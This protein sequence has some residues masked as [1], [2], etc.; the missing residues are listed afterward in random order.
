MSRNFQINLR[1]L[2]DLL[3]NHLY[4]SPEVF[5]REL[6]QNGVD[7]IQ[8][9]KLSEA[10]DPAYT[11][12][13]TV[14]LVGGERPTLIFA[15][16]GVGLSE[17]GVHRF[18]ATIGSSSKREDIEERR[19]DFIGQ[20]GIGILACFMVADEIVVLSRTADATPV[21]WRGQSDGTYTVRELETELS[22]GTQVFLRSMP[23]REEFFAPDRVRRLLA[24]FGALFPYPVYLEI[25][26]AR[27]VHIN[28]E[29]APWRRRYESE[30]E[31]RKAFVEYGQRVFDMRLFDAI[32]I[33][34]AIG[35][36]EGIACILPWAPGPSAR[37]S[38][39]VY[40]KNM[41]LTD[42]G[43][44]LLPEWA[45]FVKCVV[46]AGELQPTA[47][48]ESFYENA[49]LEQAR[50][51][52]GVCI[53]DYLVRLSRDD[54]ETLR[55]LISLHFLSFKALAAVDEEF[56]RMFIKWLPFETSL[57]TMSMGEYLER[58][59]EYVRYTTTVEEFRQISQVALAGSLP[60]INAGYVYDLDLIERLPEVYGE[61]EV[62]RIDADDLVQEF[63]DLS[64]PERDQT[65]RLM[66]VADR[67]LGNFQ[68]RPD[69]KK[70]LPADLPA[71]YSIGQEALHRRSLEQT[72]EI[73]EGLWSGVLDS[74]ARSD[75]DGSARLCFNFNN[76]LVKA[77]CAAEAE[78]LLELY[79]KMIYVQSL[80]LGH[81]PLQ[82]RELQLLNEGLGELL[83]RGLEGEHPT[84]K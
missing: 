83:L 14:R 42:N 25:D 11:G 56:Y 76:S 6:L 62:E 71:M 84:R 47:S 43:E 24:H 54:P 36:V 49:N 64:T 46:N 77:V 45:F 70:F 17:D 58:C 73:S 28:A 39:R 60:I 29:P 10:G 82:A 65:H 13:I 81:H 19:G 41:Y 44:N 18:L 59:P 27:P 7:A 68:C 50:D 16:N 5:L 31:R 22:Q 48:R 37:Q 69:M 72:R 80:L 21:E 4:S 3:S 15:D 51:Q 66:S 52:I 38:H 9:R 63:E 61:V 26:D 57:G 23:G 79:I 32:P 33:F 8:A 34:S 53:R 75:A 74:V 55:R 1:G 40:L 67:V 20:F 78:H 12:E 35:D 30:A 2:I